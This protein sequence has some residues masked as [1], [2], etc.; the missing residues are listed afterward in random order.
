MLL[1]RSPNLESATFRI[2]LRVDKELELAMDA[3]SPTYCGED[4]SKE[5]IA[6]L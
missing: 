1:L 3:R 4:G 5:L 6:F 2:Q